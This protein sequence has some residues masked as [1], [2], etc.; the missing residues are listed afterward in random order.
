MH[1]GYSPRDSLRLLQTYR[2]NH[3]I[4]QVPLQRPTL[5][6]TAGTGFESPARLPST[7][8]CCRAA[9]DFQALLCL[10]P[11]WGNSSTGERAAEPDCSLKGVVGQV[12]WEQAP[13]LSA[14]RR[15]ELN[16]RQIIKWKKG[17]AKG[18]GTGKRKKHFQTLVAWLGGM[19]LSALLLKEPSG[20][21]E[22]N[23]K[24]KRIFNAIVLASQ[25]SNSPRSS[26]V[27]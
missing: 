22:P 1:P 25:Q 16:K 6:P 4:L 18:S 27:S 2:W 21:Q 19:K 20:S 11:W 23:S 26:A 8:G 24:G 14:P 17:W 15:S 13:L 12:S 5:C 3:W 10:P 7:P 9:W